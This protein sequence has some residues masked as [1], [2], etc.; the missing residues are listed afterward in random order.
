M[1]DILENVRARLAHFRRPT[2]GSV[3]LE[4]LPV[5]QGLAAISAGTQTRQIVE[6]AVALS[7]LSVEARAA[8][9]FGVGL[10]DD[11]KQ[12]VQAI[13]NAGIVEFY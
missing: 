6:L 2:N 7:Q 13:A 1:A 11:Q 10:D 4:A 3:R 5:D 8:L 9:L 12:I